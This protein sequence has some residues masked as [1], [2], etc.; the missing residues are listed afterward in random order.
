MNTLKF[1]AI[2][3]AL[4]LVISCKPEGLRTAKP[5]KM[6]MDPSGFV[7]V[8]S[9]MNKSIADGNTSGAV[10]AVV[11]K[12]RLVFLKAYG[13]RQT[14]PEVQPMTTETIFDMASCSKCI[15][16]TL[17]IMQLIEKGQIRLHD[18]V[19]EY[20]PGFKPWVGESTRRIT[21]EHLLTHTSGLPASVNATLVSERY[22][23]NCPDSLIK[24]IATET[25]RNFEPGTDF[26]YSCVNFI[27]LQ[28]ILQNVTGDRLCDYAQKNIFDA[29]GLKHTMYLPLDRKIP[30]E[31]L[32]IVAP[33][34]VQENG[35]PLRGQVHDPTAR[36]CNWG[37][38]GN[39]GVFSTAEDCAVIAAALMNGGEINGH[40]I[41]SP[42]TV[43]LMTTVPDDIAP[44]VGRALGWDV[45]SDYS[46]MKGDITSRRHTICHTGY[47]G[48]SIV[49]DMENQL[50]II[51]MANRCHPYDEGSLNRTRATV[52]NVIAS[53]CIPSQEL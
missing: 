24:Y 47:T 7:L 10:V 11:R 34:E 31:V 1:P 29:L 18:Y 14:V 13:N 16:T 27:T 33:T 15:S 38:S 8:D 43:E 39:A 42:L 17:S 12:D 3:A 26:L 50:A 4:I 51:I 46:R 22:G 40:R 2:F 6:G 25:S 32:A 41:L 35:L 36:L 48:P 9:I 30:E 19:D 21:V 45:N 23:E 5:E 37:N 53:M 20:I 28:N 44:E 52:A 49:I